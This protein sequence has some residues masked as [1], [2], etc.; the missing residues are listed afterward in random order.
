MHRRVCNVCI[1]CIRDYFLFCSQARGNVT[2]SF[3]SLRMYC[4]SVNS[5]S[6][7][8]KTGSSIGAPAR[9]KAHATS[10]KFSGCLSSPVHQWHGSLTILVFPTRR[11]IAICLFHGCRIRTPISKR[12]AL[13]VWH[14][15]RRPAPRSC[16]LRRHRCVRLNLAKG[17]IVPCIIKNTRYSGILSKKPPHSRAG[18]SESLPP[19]NP[20]PSAAAPT[21]LRRGHSAGRSLSAPAQRALRVGATV[22]TR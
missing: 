15:R 21:G 16:R 9:P 7:F 18:I 5:K 10:I 19:Y 3:S 4:L 8:S 13:T 11:F 20:R 6:V 1:T 22:R 2:A 12:K 14:P 17:K